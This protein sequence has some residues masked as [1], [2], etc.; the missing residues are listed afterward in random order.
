MRIFQIQTD[1]S[2]N[3]RTVTQHIQRYYTQAEIYQSKMQIYKFRLKQLNAHTH[4]LQIINQLNEDLFEQ[5]E[6]NRKMCKKVSKIVTISLQDKNKLQAMK[7]DRITALIKLT[8]IKNMKQKA[9]VLHMN[10]QLQ[11]KANK[12]ISLQQTKNNCLHNYYLNLIANIKQMKNRVQTVKQQLLKRQRFYKTKQWRQQ[13]NSIIKKAKVVKILKIKLSLLNIR[14]IP[15]NSTLKC[16]KMLKSSIKSI[17][18]KQ[19]H[20]KLKYRVS[21]NEIVVNLVKSQLQN[22]PENK[23]SI[24]LRY[25]NILLIVNQYKLK[26][27]KSKLLSSQQLS[28]QQELLIQMQTSCQFN[29]FQAQNLTNRLSIFQLKKKY[30]QLVQNKV[31]I[32]STP[33]N[34]HSFNLKLNQIKH[35]IKLQK[36]YTLQSL[37]KIKNQQSNMLAKT[38]NIKFLNLF[39]KQ[40]KD[41]QYIANIHCKI[42]QLK[43]HQPNNIQNPINIILNKQKQIISLKIQKA[44]LNVKKISKFST[45][46]L[47]SKQLQLIGQKVQKIKLSKQIS[48]SKNQLLVTTAH[49]RQCEYM[50]KITKICLL[51]QNLVRQK[52]NT[53]PKYDSKEI[54]DKINKIKLLLNVRQCKQKVLTHKQ[55][56]HLSLRQDYY[57]ELHLLLKLKSQLSILQQKLLK[58]FHLKQKC[59]LYQLRYQREQSQITYQK[60]VLHINDLFTKFMKLPKAKQLDSYFQAQFEK[61]YGASGSEAAT[62]LQKQDMAYLKNERL[63]R[64]LQKTIIQQLE[65]IQEQV[66][67]LYN[68]EEDDQKLKEEF[69]CVVGVIEDLVESEEFEKE[70]LQM[71]REDQVDYFFLKSCEA[72]CTGFRNDVFQ[73]ICVKLFRVK[74][75]LGQFFVQ[76]DL[77][78]PIVVLGSW[79]VIDGI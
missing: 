1:L 14:Q 66:I 74:V 21:K 2:K 56:L 71:G 39:I 69:I 16:Q 15:L 37:L 68:T 75:L 19:L 65:N 63:I 36:Y 30:K 12:L 40:L 58:Q 64:M 31:S 22:I 62:I 57:R 35:K 73:K 24:T 29:K 76:D 54:F 45:C 59:K 27:L 38:Q 18:C 51:K 55:S 17:Q 61:I 79:V 48:L 10:S 49:D 44:R 70:F 52:L 23:Y 11:Q 60:M 26:L 33:I 9:K 34:Q 53:L 77:D 50:A 72:S 42:Q 46:N 20:L 41:K 67:D 28:Q 25:K 78:F 8:K 47:L 4:T 7:I 3:G 13:L 6:K 43:V 32:Q 5:Q